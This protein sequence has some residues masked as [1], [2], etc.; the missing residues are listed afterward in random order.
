MGR[1]VALLSASCLLLGSPTGGGQGR[2]S[3]P[4]GTRGPQAWRSGAE[5]RSALEG[6]SAANYVTQLEGG[7]SGS[8]TSAHE[9]GLGQ[10]RASG[11]RAP[12]RAR[13]V[14]RQ[15]TAMDD[16]IGTHT[17]GSPQWSGHRGEHDRA[18]LP[19]SRQLIPTSASEYPRR[20][21]HGARSDVRK[22]AVSCPRAIHDLTCGGSSVDQL[23]LIGK[24]LG[25]SLIER[26]EPTPPTG[27]ERCEVGVGDLAMTNDVSEFGS[28][29]G[30]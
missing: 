5:D 14:K 23:G 18:R 26:R 19:P 13:A 6:R 20:R 2:R 21:P 15:L 3:R 17:P 29:V 1:P 30:G 28:R 22:G 10:C 11:C 27:G 7:H 12:L 16:V 4:G 9:G 25:E 8:F 24:H